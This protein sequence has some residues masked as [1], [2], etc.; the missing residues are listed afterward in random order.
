LNE[1]HLESVLKTY[2]SHYNQE[3]PHR[4][5]DLRIPEGGPPVGQTG[6]DGSIVR[7]DRLGGL[8]HEYH[9]KAA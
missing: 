4:G 2:V 9:W 8:I 1:R 3:R 5:L 7:H 6:A